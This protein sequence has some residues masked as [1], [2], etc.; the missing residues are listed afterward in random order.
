MYQNHFLEIWSEI[1]VA[2]KPWF[3]FSGKKFEDFSET[4]PNK[5]NQFGADP[6]DVS[7]IAF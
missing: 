5:R 2:I 7:V 4:L 3:Y 1:Q 6:F